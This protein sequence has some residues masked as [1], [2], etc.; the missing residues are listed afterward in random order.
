MARKS[1][2]R[3]GRRKGFVAIPFEVV[4]TLG[5]LADVT[6][7]TFDVLG[8]FARNI[9]LISADAVITMREHTPGEGPIV[10]GFAAGDLT[11][12][13]ILEKLQAELTD[14]SDIIQMER[15]RRPVRQ[16]GVFPGLSSEE[17]LNDGRNT[18]TRLKFG[19]TNG[20]TLDV[21]AYNR[22]GNALTTGTVIN[23]LGTL[24][25]RWQ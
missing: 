8:T 24:Y 12:S 7:G 20:K 9:Y 1:R 15:S 21:W 16:T 23:V 3:R 5:S 6:V 13:E 22:S 2:R 25:G 14:P 18:R 17:A 11:S 10:Y 4:H 19:I